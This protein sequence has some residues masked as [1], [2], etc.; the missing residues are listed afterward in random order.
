VVFLLL[1]CG[2]IGTGLW[3]CDYID[4]NVVQYL[5][6]PYIVLIITLYIGLQI[7]KCI[8]YITNCNFFPYLYFPYIILIITLYIDLQ[9]LKFVNYITNCN[10]VPY[11]YF[12]YIILI[13]TLYIHLQ[14]MK[15]VNY[16][17][18]CNFVPYTY[19]PHVLSLHIL[20]THL[21]N[22][23][24][25]N[26]IPNCNTLPPSFSISFQTFPTHTISTL[27]SNTQ[28]PHSIPTHNFHTPSQRTTQTA[29]RSVERTDTIWCF[30]VKMCILVHVTG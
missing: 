17:T 7:L 25:I 19:S 28:F 8:N 13:I 22:L 9:I 3:E 6:F 20:Y 5:Y 21:Q 14:I 15:F 18:K 30:T 12:P 29:V 27:H 4:C 11:L 23:K 2:L 24:Y 26:Q 10:F 1:Y 16:I